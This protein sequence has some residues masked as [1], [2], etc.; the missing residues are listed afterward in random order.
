MTL[1]GNQTRGKLLLKLYQGISCSKECSQH[2]LLCFW[3]FNSLGLILIF[4]LKW[5][6]SRNSCGKCIE[7]FDDFWWFKCTW[8]YLATNTNILNSSQRVCSIIMQCGIMSCKEKFVQSIFE[9]CWL[10]PR[11]EQWFLFTFEVQ[12]SLILSLLHWMGL[13]RWET[14]QRSRKSPKMEISRA[15]STII[16]S[17]NMPTDVG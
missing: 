15:C 5:Q 10:N 2:L 6:F 11:S 8:W 7:Y 13:G 1:S 17:E 12:T 14:T 9:N 3:N 16:M 4:S